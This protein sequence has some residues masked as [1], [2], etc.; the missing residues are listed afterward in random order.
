M[1]SKFK[2]IL[3]R[4]IQ[5]SAS[6]K[7][8]QVIVSF[9]AKMEEDK[10]PLDEIQVNTTLKNKMHRAILAHTLKKKKKRRSTT[11]TLLFSVSFLFLTLVTTY[12]YSH[13]PFLESYTA[14]HSTRIITLADQSTITLLPGSSVY[15]SPDFNTKD[16]NI[17]FQGQAFFDVARNPQ[18][19]FTISGTQVKTSVL[20]TSFWIK[21]EGA[22]TVIEVETG[23]VKV[24]EPLHQAYVLLQP[25]E[26]ARYENQH[27]QKYNIDQERISSWSP[28][29]HMVNASFSQWKAS[30][31]Q[32]FDVI[33][34]S[35][36]LQ[37]QQIKITGDYRNSSLADILDSFC[38]INNLVYH[39]Q[40]H[41][42]TINEAK[43]HD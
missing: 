36:N 32:E 9:L 6:V 37:I 29:L 18:L 4:Y 11:K 10:L 38:F 14:T 5:G 12:Y 22:Y 20:G 15:V 17:Q 2:T 26:I 28:S 23:Q 31:E 42:I 34:L 35:K 8:E 43:T 1:E 7:E 27:L 3:T 40:N 33:I 39:N 21:E 13:Y 24:E 16:R 41:L 19:P 30:I 25:K